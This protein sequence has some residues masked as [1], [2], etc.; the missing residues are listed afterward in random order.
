MSPF[1]DVY[2]GQLISALLT[3]ELGI[4]RHPA[5]RTITSDMATKTQA[6]GK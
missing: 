2:F 5:A 3:Q 4:V 6:V 1:A